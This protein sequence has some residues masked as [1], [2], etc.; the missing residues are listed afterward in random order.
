VPHD[1]EP[2]LRGAQPTPQ[3]GTWLAGLTPTDRARIVPAIEAL[4][5]H[6]KDLGSKL[7]KPIKS[8][9]HHE[10][11]ELRAVTGN[12]RVLYGIDPNRRAVLLVGGDKTNNWRGWYDQNVPNADRA[13][14]QHLRD[15]GGGGACRSQTIG[16]PKLGR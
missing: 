13:W 3:V 10:M 1:P 15:L 8:S 11:R 7:A 6:G 16:G 14:D 4:L 2:A 12:I 5:E 9:R